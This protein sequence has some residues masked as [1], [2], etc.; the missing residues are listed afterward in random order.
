VNYSLQCIVRSANVRIAENL[1]VDRDLKQMSTEAG[2]EAKDAVD[3]DPTTSSCTRAGIRPWWT[4][5]LRELY[6]VAN[7][8]VTLPETGGDDCNYYY[9]PCFVRSTHT[10]V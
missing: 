9:R 5:D 1:A 6:V 4:V 2:G 7:V 8:S 3:N 10:L